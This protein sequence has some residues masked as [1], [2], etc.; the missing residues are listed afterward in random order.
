M[1]PGEAVLRP[2]NETGQHW[3]FCIPRHDKL[4]TKSQSIVGA[5]Q[6]GIACRR[7]RCLRPVTATHA[8]L[9]RPATRPPRLGSRPRA[10]AWAQFWSHSSPSGAVH[11]RSP[12]SCLRSS[13]T[14][15]AAGERWSALLESVLGATPQEFESPILRHADLQKHGSWRPPGGPLVLTWSQLVVSV[16]SRKWCHGQ[17]RP[18]LLCLVTGVVNGPE[19]TG[20]RR[21][22][23]RPTVQGMPGPSAT[24]VQVALRA[25]GYP[26]TDRPHHAE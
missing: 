18:Q 26:P 8:A 17:D 24:G 12:G 6:F 13:R 5:A 16:M 21:R 19:R 20:A 3:P 9:L 15:A 7:N 4:A 10:W 25:A 22:S 23:V 2:R 14:V 1:S 11:R